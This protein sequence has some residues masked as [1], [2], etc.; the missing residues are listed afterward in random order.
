MAVKQNQK[1][2]QQ[3]LGRIEKRDGKYVFVLEKEP[4]RP[5]YEVVQYKD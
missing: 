4:E 1:I 2:K 5:K 3:L